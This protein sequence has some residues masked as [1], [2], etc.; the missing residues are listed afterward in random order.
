MLSVA[1]IYKIMKV[2]KIT[3]DEN[4]YG[5]YA[6][7]KTEA[8]A[9]LIDEIGFFE[10]ETVE[11]I[12]GVAEKI[13][14]TFSA[15]LL[16]INEQIALIQVITNK[17]CN[18]NIENLNILQTALEAEEDFIKLSKSVYDK[19]KE[20]SSLT[21]GWDDLIMSISNTHESHVY[22]LKQTLLNQLNRTV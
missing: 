17:Y 7:N 19:M 22:L 3:V 10:N 16:N 8:L 18:G 6:E 9:Y 15:D 1:E 14:G 4:Y 2:F 5:I 13:A 12:D 21:L 11:E 20:E